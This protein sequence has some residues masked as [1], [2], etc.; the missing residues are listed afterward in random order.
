M[1]GGYK[2]TLI[3]HRKILYLVRVV[4]QTMPLPYGVNICS[5]KSSFNMI[6]S[7][8]VSVLT[9]PDFGFYW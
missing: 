5:N 7:Q 3:P 2:K 1:S 4:K 8:K 9:N 6:E